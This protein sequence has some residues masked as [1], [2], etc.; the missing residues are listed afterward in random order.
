M[1]ILLTGGSSFT[2]LWFA[3]ALHAA[4]HELVATLTKANHDY[5]GL[6]A[7]RVAQ[8]GS[9]AELVWT[10]RLG[11]DA[12]LDLVRSRPFDI[13]AH[14]AAHV[15]D[16]RAPDY[17]VAHAVA[18]NTHRLGDILGEMRARGLRGMIATGSVFE[19]GEGAGEA[20]LR[21]VSP[22]GTAKA[23]SARVIG[24]V[25]ATLAVPWCKFV[26]PN[27]FGPMEEARFCHYLI[28]A[29]QN[30][31]TPIVRTPHYVRDNLPVTIAAQLYAEALSSLA[32]APAPVSHA[33]PS[34]YI[35]SQA[36]FAERLA[37]ECGPRLGIAPT[38]A[39]AAQTDFSEPLI[40]TNT[41][42]AFLGI[43]PDALSEFWDQYA[44][45]YAS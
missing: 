30:R 34:G 24:A 8:L 25:C 41:Q 21:A 22:Y 4:G 14:H 36:A 37:R 42:P 20:P 40:R 28:R 27:P 18:A 5:A 15:G 39:F 31:E 43:A 26:L 35:E 29:W 12:F 2:G 16:Y 17:N 13:L 32:E 10:T 38:L 1:R 44:A 11:D 19:P 23:E 9:C 33:A 7:R 45:S 6:R 3:R